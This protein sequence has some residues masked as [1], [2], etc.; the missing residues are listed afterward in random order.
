MALVC[1]MPT[2]N[3]SLAKDLLA[4]ETRYWQA[5]KD[6]DADAALALTHDPCVV[7]GAQGVAKIDRAAHKKMIEEGGSA[8][9]LEDF[10]LSEP[11]VEM[12]S[13]DV[14]VLGYK[15]HEKLTV[16]GK[17]LSLDAADASTW[18][19]KNGEWRCALHTESI[20]GDPFGRDRKA[21][22]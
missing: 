2:T 16:E 18:V 17:P 7:T 13:D 11:Q 5:I 3:Q 19:R 10:T 21:K 20:L 12:I 1:A 6:Q 22:A 14:A 4:L 9:T 15:V 8:Y